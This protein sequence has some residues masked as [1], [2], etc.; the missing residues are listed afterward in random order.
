V[1]AASLPVAGVD[2]TLQDRMR[3]GRARGRCHAKTGTLPDH[4]VS[5]LAGWCADRG[6]TLVFAFL[7]EGVDSESSAKGAEDAMVQRLLK[8][9]SARSSGTAR[10]S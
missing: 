2:G 7:R 10:R 6:R 5:A 1:L 3:H 4:R 9:P 8:R